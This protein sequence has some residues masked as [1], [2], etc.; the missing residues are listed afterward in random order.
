[1]P[2][3]AVATALSAA[4]AAGTRLAGRR[5]I[6]RRAGVSEIAEL[7]RAPLPVCDRLAAR[8][9]RRAVLLAAGSGSA[10]GVLGA[11]GLVL[12]IPSLL[13][14]SFRLI[15]GLGLCYGEELT[16]DRGQ[17]LA[18]AIFALATAVEAEDKRTALDALERETMAAAPAL[19]LGLQRGIAR[20]AAKD[21]I[22]KAVNRLAGQLGMQLGWR[23]AA[24]S[25]PVVGAAVGASV[26]AW[27]MRTLGDTARNAFQWRY[28]QRRQVGAANRG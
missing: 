5:S 8:L 23:K 24:E 1:M 7:A 14:Q 4:H 10:F 12:D 15:F 20:E 27:A 17:V 13:V 28:L 2:A 16:G 3:S 11:P 9:S 6:L 18:L 19:R 26:N 22:A 21:A 25:L